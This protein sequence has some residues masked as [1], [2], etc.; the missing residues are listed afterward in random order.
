MCTDHLFSIISPT[1]V[2][3][4]I[5][6]FIHLMVYCCFHRQSEEYNQ[7]EQKVRYKNREYR[8]N[9]R[10]PLDAAPGIR[11]QKRLYSNASC[12]FLRFL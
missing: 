10:G 12:D 8:K 1:R 4:T 6:Y 2:Q 5:T 7:K 11:L 3:N 9:L